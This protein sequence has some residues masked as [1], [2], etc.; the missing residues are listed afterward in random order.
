LS[1]CFAVPASG[2]HLPATTICRKAHA[3]RQ[4][5]EGFNSLAPL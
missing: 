2:A 1:D 4:L 3:D 5:D